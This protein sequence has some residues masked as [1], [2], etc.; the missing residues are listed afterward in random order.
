MEDLIII[1]DEIDYAYKH[2]ALLGS[3]RDIVDETLSIVILVGMQTSKD[4][5]AQKKY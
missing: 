2:E 3:I 1:I 5:L 4:R